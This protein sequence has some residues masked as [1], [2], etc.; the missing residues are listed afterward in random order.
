[1]RRLGARVHSVCCVPTD[2]FAAAH[3][4]HHRSVCSTYLRA[5]STTASPSHVAQ[6]P[7][8]APSSL[9]SCPAHTSPSPS[10]PF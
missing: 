7:T 4:Q 8:P 1:M 2:G 5:T 10:Y 6:H 3:L 9:H